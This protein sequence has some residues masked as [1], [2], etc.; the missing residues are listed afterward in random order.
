[1]GFVIGREMTSPRLFAQR[2][3]RV[4]YISNLSERCKSHARLKDGGRSTKRPSPHSPA[5][6]E[7]TRRSAGTRAL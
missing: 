3:G 6:G 7:L 1:M 5:R 2:A 4:L